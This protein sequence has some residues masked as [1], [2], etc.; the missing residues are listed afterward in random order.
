MKTLLAICLLLAPALPARAYLHESSSLEFLADTSPDIG[1]YAAT[2]VSSK[3]FDGTPDLHYY[4]ITLKLQETIKGK[5]P[6]NE[7]V[8]ETDSYSMD[9]AKKIAGSDRFLVFFLK[10]GAGTRVEHVIDLSHPGDFQDT[11]RALAINAKLQLI[12]DGDTVLN[13]VRERMKAHPGTD[14][15]PEGKSR[16]EHIVS[17]TE[18]PGL[19]LGFVGD[20]YQL[21][22]PDDFMP[23][24]R[25]AEE[26]RRIVA[27]LRAYCTANHVMP[28]GNAA[29]IAAALCGDNKQKQEYLQA[30]IPK[31]KAGELVDPWGTPY[32]IQILNPEIPRAYSCGPNKK[33]E[34]GE[35]GTDDIVSW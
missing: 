18:I 31:N 22:V 34:G 33:D 3:D 27:A 11:P 2:A 9:K 20:A 32:R 13:V 14:P 17:L 7:K 6:E 23:P 16:Y 26:A 15:L 10:D 28:A 29:Q 35:T 1:I 24:L 5:P 8:V 21:F 30:K 12:A 19:P 25:A 4:N